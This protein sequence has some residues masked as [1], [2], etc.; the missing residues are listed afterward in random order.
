M[1]RLLGPGRVSLW[2]LLCPTCSTTAGQ[3]PTFVTP[4]QPRQGADTSVV[5]LPVLEA[6]AAEPSRTAVRFP[7]PTPQPSLRAPAAAHAPTHVCT[8]GCAHRAANPPLFSTAQSTDSFGASSTFGGW[9]QMQKQQE[10]KRRHSLVQRM[11]EGA[12]C[13]LCPSQERHEL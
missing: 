6:R 12:L 2:S 7:G 8:Q 11:E 1:L 5:T 10:G 3:S 13:S 4:L 9:R